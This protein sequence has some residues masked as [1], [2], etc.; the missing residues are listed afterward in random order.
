[1]RFAAAA[2]A[3]FASACGPLEAVRSG[4]TLCAL[5]PEP[6]VAE[7]LGAVTVAPQVADH[8]SCRW[9]GATG[10]DG[11]PRFMT[12]EIWR[13]VALRRRLPATTGALFFEAQLHALEQ[14]YPRT[15]V[16]GT[17][18]EAAVF[19]F[20]EVGDE[21]FSGAILIRR[22]GDVL[23]MRIDGADPEAFER[24]ARRISAKM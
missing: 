19:G 13:D 7:A 2:L 14:E 8:P 11:I 22:G 1:V 17:D 10:A 21:R 20:G 5:A 16:I 12:A 9:D 15:R 6:E 24:V 23:S 4:A 3:L 18:V